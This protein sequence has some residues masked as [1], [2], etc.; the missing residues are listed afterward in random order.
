MELGNLYSAALMVWVAAGLQEAGA[1]G[2]DL[3]ASDLLMIGYGSGDASEVLA[4]RVVAGWQ[5]AAAKTNL[6]G[7]LDGA[8]DL[9]QVQYEALHDGAA[10]RDLLPASRSGFVIERIGDRD[11]PDFTD[12]GVEYYRHASRESDE[13]S[14]RYA[15]T[16]AG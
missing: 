10:V 2:T 7:A 8:I 14:E 11:E 5:E 1:A 3:S 12:Y 16:A 9:T 4:A 13:L 15:A 6:R